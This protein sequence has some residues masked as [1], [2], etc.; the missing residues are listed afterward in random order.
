MNSKM[1]RLTVEEQ[2]IVSQIR[3]YERFTSIILDTISEKPAEF[4]KLT[5]EEIMMLL[6]NKSQELQTELIHIQL[7]KAF[8]IKEN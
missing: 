5:V 6:H 7:S 8:M 1:E 3:V 4:H 2:Q